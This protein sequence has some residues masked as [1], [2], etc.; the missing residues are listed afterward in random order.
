MGAGVGCGLCSGLGW[1]LGLGR[2]L[3]WRLT[4]NLR[5]SGGSGGLQAELEIVLDLRLC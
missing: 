5:C 1:R 4:R 3:G 2:W